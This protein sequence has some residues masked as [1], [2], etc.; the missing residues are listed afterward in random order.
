M[1]VYADNI[2]TAIDKSI[3]DIVRRYGD[4]SVLY[5]RTKQF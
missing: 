5:I 1:I 3:D 4:N 2:C